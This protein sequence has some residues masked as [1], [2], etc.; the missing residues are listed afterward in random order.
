MLKKI[1]NKIYKLYYTS[2][3]ERYIKYLHRKKIKIGEGCVILDPKKIQ[4]DVSRPELL[5]IGDYVFLHRGTIILTHD[6]ASW[7]FVN[8]HQDFIPSH[9]KIKIGNNVWLGENVTILKNVTI[10]DNVIIGI[11]SIVTK[12]IPSNSIAVGSPAKVICTYDDY[13][14]KRKYQYIDECFEYANS[15]LNSGRELEIK[16]FYDDY[17]I[18]VNETNYKYY[19]YPYHHIFSKEQ[20]NKWK[21]NHKSLFNGFEEFVTAVKTKRNEHDS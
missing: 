2:S 7:C 15:I 9:G 21:K 16:D 17:P 3:S 11:G 18:F 4:I 5:E 12:D 14:K 8:S 6:W 10:G 20:F 19:N 13:Y 1:A